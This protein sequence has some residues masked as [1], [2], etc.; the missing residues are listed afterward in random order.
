MLVIYNKSFGLCLMGIKIRFTVY[1]DKRRMCD[2][3]VVG[4]IKCVFKVSDF[5]LN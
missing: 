4:S 5:E 2:W 1:F 3:K